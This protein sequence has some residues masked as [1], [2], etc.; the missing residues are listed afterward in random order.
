MV[1]KWPRSVVTFSAN[2]WLVIQREM[3]T[4]MAATFSSPTHTPV[5]PG[6]RPASTSN[7][8]R[9]RMIASSRPRTYF[10]TSLRSG[11]RSRMGYPTSWPGPW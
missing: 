7:R 10:H 3:R 2:P 8:A 5:R 11:A 1:S 9:E 6:I 4:P